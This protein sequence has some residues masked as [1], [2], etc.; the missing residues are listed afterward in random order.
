VLDEISPQWLKMRSI[1]SDAENPFSGL[2][3]LA[4]I[5]EDMA[6]LHV[7]FEPS[8]DASPALGADRRVKV[9]EVVLYYFP[10]PLTGK[11]A[12]MDSMDKMRPVIGRSEAL[13]VHD[14]WALKDKENEKGEKSMVYVN[15]VGWVD[16]DAHMRF[17]ASEDFK[18]NIHH[19]LDIKSIQQMEMHHVQLHRV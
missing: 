9:T 3:D 12:I 2:R 16:V 18:E 7:P 15:V 17:Q 1:N 13:A 5:E 8:Q 4:S 19:L 6:V 11:A 10:S 14:G